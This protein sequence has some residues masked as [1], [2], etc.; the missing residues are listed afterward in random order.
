MNRGQ[1]K[2]VGRQTGQAKMGPAAGNAHLPLSALGTLLCLF[3]LVGC[4]DAL[5]D[6]LVRTQCPL[7]A[8]ISM[9]LCPLTLRIGPSL[10]LWDVK[11]HRDVI[12]SANYR[13]WGTW[14]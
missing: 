8:T 10:R 3:P 11:L 6:P 1:E 5:A 4:T 9:G 2:D 12:E 7:I 14:P 13:G